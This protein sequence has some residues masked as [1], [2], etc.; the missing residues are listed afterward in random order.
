MTDD[1]TALL[2]ASRPP[3]D[4]AALREVSVELARE[5]VRT[6]RA[7]RA[8]RRRRLVGVV[9]AIAVAV[10]ATAAATYWT[11]HT[12]EHGD[13][14]LSEENASEWLD[15]CAPDFASVAADLA[16]TSH[17]LPAGVQLDDGDRPRRR[18]LEG[19]LSTRGRRARRPTRPVVVRVL[20]GLRLGRGVAARRRPR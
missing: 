4:E 6:S 13:P 11:T 2:T 19:G 18:E 8:R 7:A 1:L 12:G 3:V 9:A 16:P 14:S 5:T 10:P 15:V 20:R 17:A